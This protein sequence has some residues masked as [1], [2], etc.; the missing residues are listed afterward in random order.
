MDTREEIQERLS[1]SS[2]KLDQAR[3]ALSD[4]MTEK[5]TMSEELKH[6]S[7]EMKSLEHRMNMTKLARSGETEQVHPAEHKIKTLGEEIENLEKRYDEF[8]HQYA[9]LSGNLNLQEQLIAD[10]TAQVNT[11]EVEVAE[12]EKT[13]ANLNDGEMPAT[14]DDQVIEYPEFHAMETADSET[15]VEDAGAEIVRA[16]R[17]VANRREMLDQREVELKETMELLHDRLAEV[18][19]QELAVMTKQTEVEAEARRLVGLKD[20]LDQKSNDLAAHC[21]ELERRK[22]E[23]ATA[24]ERANAKIAE[25]VKMERAALKVDF[26][27]YEAAMAELGQQRVTLEAAIEK[28]KADRVTLDRDLVE[29][30]LGW[31]ELEAERAELKVEREELEKTKSTVEKVID[32]QFQK[33]I[34]TEKSL[35]DHRKRLEEL[36]IQ[37]ADREKAVISAEKQLTAAKAAFESVQLR[38]SLEATATTPPPTTTIEEMMAESQRLSGVLVQMREDAEK[39][40]IELVRLRSELEAK[41]TEL[42]RVTAENNG[43]LVSL[44]LVREEAQAATK[45]AEEAQKN[46]RD[47]ITR[48][49]QTK[50]EIAEAQAVLSAGRAQHEADLTEHQQDVAEHEKAVA[51][52]I[53]LKTQT[54]QAAAE[55]EQMKNQVV[56][57][58]SELSFDRQSHENEVRGASN[59]LEQAKKLVNSFGLAKLPKNT[60]EFDTP[61]SVSGLAKQINT[62]VEEAGESQRSLEGD[63]QAAGE[64]SASAARIFGLEVSLKLLRQQGYLLEL[65]LNALRRCEKLYEEVKGG[66]E[67]IGTAEV[68]AEKEIEKARRLA[69]EAIITAN[70]RVEKLTSKKRGRSS[71][72]VFSLAALLN[73]SRL[74]K[75]AA[76]VIIALLGLGVGLLGINFGKDIYRGAK[77]LPAQLS[78]TVTVS[79]PQLVPYLQQGLTGAVKV[80]SAV[81][82][83]M[84]NLTSTPEA[85]AGPNENEPNH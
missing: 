41:Q 20:H 74:V 61:E 8:R 80:G 12:H 82:E 34:A 39:R 25:D 65:A 63:L 4:A 84:D 47:E 3:T 62:M 17:D 38:Q 69:E 32:D 53:A 52:L 11:L 54:T 75:I 37:L 59:E 49:E 57:R 45:A 27:R 9:I 36:E 46:A 23:I 40:N 13:L 56:A 58:S 66:R 14:G 64:A 42:E 31:S 67:A 79:A 85:A 33:N 10:L 22:A 15:P 48:L 29:Q 18:N 51:E 7:G 78:K 77:D 81:V 76:V 2:V 35:H 70:A 60:P 1:Q 21:E 50:A 43:T 44:D 72:P 6:K 55:L 16:V 24:K 68:R 26:E 71:S 19:Q 30:N 28:L 5:N 83:F 73:R